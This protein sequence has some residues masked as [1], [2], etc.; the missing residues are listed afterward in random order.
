MCWLVR[1]WYRLDVEAKEAEAEPREG[2]RGGRG[3][4]LVLVSLMGEE[5]AEVGG[6]AVILDLVGEREEAVAAIEVGEV[7][8]SASS[9]LS[10]WKSTGGGNEATCR[11]CRWSQG[12]GN[13]KEVAPSRSW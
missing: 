11:I 13:E 9:V 2:G 4:G 1:W 7:Q 10:E 8:G 12:R 6:V 5:A 3:R